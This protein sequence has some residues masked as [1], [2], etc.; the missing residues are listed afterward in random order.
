MKK[1][2]SFLLLALPIQAYLQTTAKKE[3]APITVV[4]KIVDGPPNAMTIFLYERLGLI[5]REVARG[6]RQED[7]SYIITLPSGE[8]RVYYIGFNDAQ[9]TPVILGKEKNLTL[10]AHAQYMEKGRTVGSEIN[11]AYENLRKEA[12]QLRAQNEELH[13]EQREARLRGDANAIKA[14][15]EKFKAH[16]EAKANFVANW[17]KNNPPLWRSATL[18]VWPDDVSENATPTSIVDFYAREFFAYANLSDPAYE[19]VPEVFDAFLTYVT[20][21][22]QLGA[23]AAQIKS[24]LDSHLAKLPKGSMAHRRAFGGALKAMQNLNYPDLVAYT[25]LYTE[26]FKDKDLGDVSLLEAELRRTS[27]FIPGMLVPDLVGA[28]PKGDTISL[29]KTLKGK[30]VLIDFWA[31]WCGPCRRE[32][33]NVVALYKKYKNKGFDVFGVSLDRDREAWIRAIEQDGLTWH[34]ISDLQG[35]RSEHAAL[36]S[37][38]SIPQT[39]LIDPQGRIIQRN[40]RGEQLAEKLREI[41]GE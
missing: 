6:Q 30:Y 26:T 29:L 41:F 11:R 22:N 21:L 5:S 10:W 28:T 36:Y 37:V 14:V 31:S 25:K 18:L 39:I 19:H 40:L 34:H 15:R 23:N 27:T 12:E 24:G 16:N 7:G 33:P 4:C 17:K 8:P 35:W 2:L 32:N 20:F 3:N 1:V 38:S 9:T 13:N